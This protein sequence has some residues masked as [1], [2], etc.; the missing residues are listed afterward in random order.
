[1]KAAVLYER[2]GPLVV[3]DLD[4]APPEGGRGP[5]Q[6]RRERHLPQ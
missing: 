6:D 4:L 1:M 3:E 2:K 5:R